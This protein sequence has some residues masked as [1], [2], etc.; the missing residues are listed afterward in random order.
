[1]KQVLREILTMKIGGIKFGDEYCLVTMKGKTGLKTI[2]V[3]TSLQ[4]FA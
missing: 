1:M 2:P 3:V 4:V